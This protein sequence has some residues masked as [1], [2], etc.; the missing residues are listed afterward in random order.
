MIIELRVKN[1]AITVGIDVDDAGLERLT[2]RVME[3]NEPLVQNEVIVKLSH[4][5]QIESFQLQVCHSCKIFFNF[6]FSKAY[7]AN[8]SHK[9]PS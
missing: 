8:V 5:K 1:R 2:C 6:L 3:L 9:G 7:T 4:Q